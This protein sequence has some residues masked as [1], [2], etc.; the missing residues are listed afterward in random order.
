MQELKQQGWFK[1]SHSNNN[2]V[3]VTQLSPGVIG[4]RN[5][6]Q[7]GNELHLTPAAFAWLVAFARES[8]THL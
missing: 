2:C 3:E 6:D 5:S 1:S 7:P 8:V 4:V